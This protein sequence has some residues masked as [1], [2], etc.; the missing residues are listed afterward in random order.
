MSPRNTTHK[1]GIPIVALDISPRKTHAVLAGREILK[2]IEVSGSTC[3]EDFNLRAAVITYAATHHT[4]G[5]AVSAK[6]KDQLAANDVKSSHGKFDTTIGTAAANGQIVI[7]DVNR[8]GVE[9]ARLHE[10]VRQVHR[11]AVNPHQGALLLSGSQDA[12][13][14]LWDLR[15]LAG[16]RSVMTCRSS[17]QYPGNNEGVRDLSWSPTNGV[18]FAAGTDNGV[19]QRWDL[20]KTR[21]PMLKV[22]AH[23]KTC[24]AVEW[25]PDGKHLVSGGADKMVNVWDFSS[26]DRRKKAAW[27]LR[28]P[29]AVLNVRWRPPRGGAPG[30]HSGN[31]QCSQVVTSYDHQD[32]RI[33]VWDFR[34][35]FMPFREIDRF[36]TAPTAMLWQ[37]ED[38]LWSVDMQGI[39]AQ[40]DINGATPVSH[41]RSTSVVAI[42]PS[43]QVGVVAER[44]ARRQR[45]L[46]DAT[47]DFLHRHRLSGG[48]AEKMSRSQSATDGSLEEASLLSS[49]LKN[50]HRNPPSVKSAKS[51]AGT[52]P[53][54]GTGVS[55]SLDEAMRKE[56]AFQPGQV[57]A[58]GHILGLFDSP[59][60][61]F[62]AR[63]YKPSAATASA[64]PVDSW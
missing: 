25:H 5:G 21:A 17:Y 55:V 34:R 42:A 41:T 23:E 18:E 53:S 27:Q 9:L 51:I 36:D 33:H 37:S 49:S 6:H 32:P 11:L 3:V 4:A 35:P 16:D 62:L 57:A 29:Q 38:L 13:M 48:G 14:R 31:W 64:C 22:N 46:Q 43:G 1:T 7:Y 30:D 39:F 44:R 8:V 40:M 47:D 12:T 54:G 45:S 63:N 61:A 28:A 26:T 58:Y 56:Y 2:T 60:F 24:H 59:G 20:R 19:I 52:P 50:R 15:D 10:H